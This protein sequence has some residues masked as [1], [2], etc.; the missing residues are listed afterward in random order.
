MAD[1][2]LLLGFF[3]VFNVFLAEDKQRRRHGF[4]LASLHHGQREHVHSVS[5][6]GKT[7]EFWGFFPLTQD[8]LLSCCSSII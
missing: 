6:T 3:N 4:P 5:E 8:K 1:F 2:H 7:A